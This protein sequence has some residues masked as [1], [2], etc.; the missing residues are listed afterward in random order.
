MPRRAPRFDRIVL[1]FGLGLAAATFAYWTAVEYDR[2][3][4]W[5][6]E[7]AVRGALVLGAVGLLALVL[8]MAIWAEE[9]D[10]S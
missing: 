3:G 10:R 8:R 4:R 7:G 2:Y 6:G 9:R 1:P 5:L